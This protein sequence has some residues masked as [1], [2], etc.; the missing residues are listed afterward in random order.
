[1]VRT[2]NAFETADAELNW[3]RRLLRQ[4]GVFLTPNVSAATS[5][6]S[7]FFRYPRE[8]VAQQEFERI[9]GICFPGRTELGSQSRPLFSADPAQQVALR[10]GT[11]DRLC[12][13]GCIVLNE[14]HA[15]GRF[16]FAP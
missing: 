6:G 10:G 7:R 15:T 9:C 2:K 3:D 8:N 12:G 16:A 13:T 5:I 14:T 4:N 11:R 1:M